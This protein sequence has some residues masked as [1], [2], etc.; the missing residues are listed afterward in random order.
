MSCGAQVHEWHKKKAKGLET[1]AA[2]AKEK[3]KNPRGNLM[4]RFI[5]EGQKV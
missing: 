1:V 5:Q 4:P 3:G 2:A